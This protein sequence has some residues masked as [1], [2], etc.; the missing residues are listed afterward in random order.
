MKWNV[1]VEE[2]DRI[3]EK[4]KTDLRH[5][6]FLHALTNFIKY[7]KITKQQF[8]SAEVKKV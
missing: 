1:Q 6:N 8:S 2:S 4:L 5:F 3:I 7:L